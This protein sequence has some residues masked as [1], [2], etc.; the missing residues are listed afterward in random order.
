MKRVN[1]R[2]IVVGL[3]PGAVGTKL[4]R[5]FQANIAPGQ[6]FDPGRAAVQLLDVIDGLGVK[7]SG[8]LVHWDGTTLA[9]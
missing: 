7:N 9:P 4:G 3:H 5:P 1:D 8:S 6:L 2:A